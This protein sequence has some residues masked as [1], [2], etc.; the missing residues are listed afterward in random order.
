MQAGTMQMKSGQFKTTNRLDNFASC[1]DVSRPRYFASV[2]SCVFPPLE[3]FCGPLDK[4]G[5]GP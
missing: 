4:S 3:N 1:V 5:D 2:P